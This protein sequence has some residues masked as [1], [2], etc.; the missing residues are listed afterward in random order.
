MVIAGLVGDNLGV[1]AGSMADIFENIAAEMIGTI[2]LDG[3]LSEQVGLESL[4]AHHSSRPGRCG[5]LLCPRPPHPFGA[6]EGRGCW[7]NGPL[8][9]SNKL[10]SSQMATLKPPP[11]FAVILPRLGVFRLDTPCSVLGPLYTLG[12]GAGRGCL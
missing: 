11:L 1:C 2:I 3:T 4:V 10:S 8:G 12:E 5:L 9:S 7:E 6:G